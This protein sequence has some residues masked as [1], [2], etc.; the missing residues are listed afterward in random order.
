MWQALTPSNPQAFPNPAP[1]GDSSFSLRYGN[2]TPEELIGESPSGVGL[3][4]LMATYRATGGVARGDD[5]ARLLE[6]RGL[7]DFVDLARLIASNEVFGFKWRDT[8]WIPMFQVEL[9]DLSIKPATQ[10]VLMQLGSRFDGWARAAWFAQPNS[11]LNDRRP[12]DSLDS[13]LADVLRA[14]SIARLITGG[15]EP[16]VRNDVSEGKPTIAFRIS[17]MTGARCAGAV[18]KAVRAID[19]SAVVR[20]DMVALKVD[21]EPTKANARE[22]SD[23]IKRAGYTPI[24][25]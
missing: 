21:I 4:A 16:I 2:P 1:S 18:T 8:L 14:A 23:A 19:R 9:R 15:S 22:L 17:D 24:A 25:A 10:L 5:L 13:H 3:A 12:V 7:G 6:D 11:W 20:I